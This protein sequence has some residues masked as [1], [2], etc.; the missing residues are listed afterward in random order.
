MQL[1]TKL[2]AGFQCTPAVCAGVR[3]FPPQDDQPPTQES[4]TVPDTSRQRVTSVLGR[5]AL[6]KMH[7]PCPRVGQHP[8][9][10]SFG[11]SELSGR[12]RSPP[13]P[14]SSREEESQGAAPNVT[15]RWNPDKPPSWHPLDPGAEHDPCVE[16]RLSRPRTNVSCGTGRTSPSPFSQQAT[17]AELFI[18]A[19]RSLL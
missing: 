9:D 1:S 5:I 3:P 4:I 8:R 15:M 6:E 2:R 16:I 13:N 17:P 18:P 10:R 19:G 14:S 7:S 12:A 11:P